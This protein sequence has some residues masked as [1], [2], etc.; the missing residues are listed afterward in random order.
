IIRWID[1]SGNNN[2]AGQATEANRPT[3]R[4]RTNNMRAN[5]M[6][7]VSFTSSQ[8]FDISGD[9]NIRSIVA[10]IVQK[11]TQ[12]A[13]TKPFGG[14]QTLTNTSNRFTLG[15]IDSG[16]T[17]HLMQ[18]VAWQMAPGSYS[19]HVNGANKGSSSSSLTPAAFNKVGNDFAGEILEVVAYD[20][21]L[22]DGVRQKLEGY[23]AHKWDSSTSTHSMVGALPSSHSYKNTKPAF[24]GTQILTFQPVS[25]KQVGQAATLTVTADSGLTTFSFDS[26][27]STVASFGGNAT[28]GYTVTGLKEGKVT[29]TATQPGQAPW[30]SA[31][32]TQPF[33]VTSAPRQDQNIT[34]ADID[35]RNVQSPSF[36]LDA[37]ATSGLAVS[38]ESLHPLIATVETNGTVTIVGP[39]V[40]T[41]RATQAGN[42]SY[43]PAQSVEKTLTVTKVPQTITFGALA[44]A[45]LF[46]GSYSLSGKATASSGLA[47]SY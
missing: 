16:S 25:D 31:T 13:A 21:A 11:N 37:N 36:N 3:Y 34:F 26:N 24:G 39:G 45:G 6:P 12:Y 22:S 44:D 28:D 38:F 2:H 47:V 43:N 46:S 35:D 1:Q 27:D 8:S 7:S 20:R 17:S 18:I 30:N 4:M 41:I 33:I 14:D 32:A 29:I 40:A 19:I 23:I 15:A 42:N 9:S 5:D 10:L